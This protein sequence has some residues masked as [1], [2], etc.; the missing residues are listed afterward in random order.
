MSYT[1]LSYQDRYVISHLNLVGFSLREIGRRLGRHHT[2]ISREL[3]RNGPSHSVYW[4]DWV[5][6]RLKLASIRP[7][8]TTSAI[9]DDCIDTFA[10]VSARTGRRNR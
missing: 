9:T 10:I 4:Y 3:E 8:I 2:T 7:G 5:L 1:H 6:P